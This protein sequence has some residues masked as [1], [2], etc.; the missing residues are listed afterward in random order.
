MT[1]KKILVDKISL[2]LI[3]QL[4]FYEEMPPEAYISPTA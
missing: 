1:W 4:T 2:Y 3:M